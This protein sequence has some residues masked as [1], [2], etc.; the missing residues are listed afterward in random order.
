MTHLLEE[1][2]R[3]HNAGALNHAAELYET[4]LN[5]EPSHFKALNALGVLRGQLNQPELGRQTLTK[6][7]AIDPE[8][9]DANANMGLMLG[10]LGQYPQAIGFLSKAIEKHPDQLNYMLNLAFLLMDY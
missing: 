3:Q 9:G 8:N 1:A 4:F 5:G 2:I 6:A 7:L 10:K